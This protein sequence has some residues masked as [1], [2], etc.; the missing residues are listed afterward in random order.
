[1]KQKE[2]KMEIVVTLSEE[3]VDNLACA[4][5]RQVLDVMESLLKPLYEEL[6]EIKSN[7]D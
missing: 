3:S 2:M 6:K 4:I 7:T 1:M 5:G